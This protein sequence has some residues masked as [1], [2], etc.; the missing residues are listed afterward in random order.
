MAQKIKDG[1]EVPHKDI[2]KLNIKSWN[3]DWQLR[4]IGD[5]G[6][7]V[8]MIFKCKND[9]KTIFTYENLL[10]MSYLVGNITDYK[11]WPKYCIRDGLFI[12]DD[13]K[14]NEYGKH[15]RDGYGCIQESYYNL[16]QALSL[17]Y[18]KD[19]T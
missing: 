13:G 19:E 7:Y 1:T 14:T 11:M 4:E 3:V 12:K 15:V 16:T 8:Y 5:P 9:C 10:D 6:D 18:Y 17:S 2:V